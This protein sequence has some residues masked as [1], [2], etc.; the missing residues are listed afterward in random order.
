MGLKNLFRK[1]SGSAALNLYSQ[2]AV[3]EQLM[4]VEPAPKSSERLPNAIRIVEDKKTVRIEEKQAPA[5]KKEL[6]TV[7]AGTPATPVCKTVTREEISLR[8]WEIWQREGCPDG[9]AVRHWL[10]AEA[11]LRNR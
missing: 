10:Q 11:E 5:T 1:S 3:G 7:A 6:K 2:D 4:R 8:A 9:Q